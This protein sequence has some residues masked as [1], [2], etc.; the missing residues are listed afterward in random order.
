MTNCERLPDSGGALR[1]LVSIG[2][3]TYNRAAG[4]EK[5]VKSVLDQQYLNVE[6]T[7]SDNASSDD[8]KAMVE[9]LWR[10]E[11]RVRY[12]RQ[13]R[14]V[15]PGENFARAR[16]GASGK[17]FMW[18]ADD[19]WLGTG[20]LSTCVEALEADPSLV[21]VSGST[22]YYREHKFLFDAKVISLEQTSR[23]Q[24]VLEYY[25]Q[26]G[27]N[28]IFYGLMRREATGAIHMPNRIG[29]DWF[30]IADL[31][32]LGKVKSLPEIVLHRDY[33]WDE[34]SAAKLAAASNLHGLERDLPYLAIANGAFR[35]I[36]QEQPVY[37]QLSPPVRWWLAA[38]SWRII[39]RR[40]KLG[41]GRLSS[42]WLRSKRIP[43]PR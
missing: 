17:Y 21:L 41:I 39:C 15:P 43:N 20:F 24:R 11:P 2:I 40:N 1:P 5:A 23:C 30:F 14:G 22:R 8:T 32:F 13:E 25:R 12:Y 34:Q 35:R 31:A 37:Q 29:G 3:P 42:A 18:L 16:S 38:R 33:T 10:A 6:V 7:I 9:R 36:W 19:D 4:L 26:V 28:G 27:D